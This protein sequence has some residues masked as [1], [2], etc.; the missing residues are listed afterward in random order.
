MYFRPLPILTVLT[1]LILAGL[2]WLGFWQLD[3]MA[4]KQSEI[5]I[6]QAQQDRDPVTLEQA[7]C[8]RANPFSWRVE[9]PEM[10]SG[11]I[12]QI[13]GRDPAGTPGWRIFQAAEVG[14]CATDVYVLA[15]VG[16]LPLN[17]PRMNAIHEGQM[18]L[19]RPLAS[20]AFTPEREPASLE[21]YSFDR[22]AME[23]VLG[24]ADGSLWEQ[25]WLV[26]DFGALPARLDQTPPARHFGYAITWFG[27]SLALLAVYGVFHYTHG[28]LG[29][30]GRK[31]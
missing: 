21:F 14:E 9:R 10:A 23:N 6:W 25:G 18:M 1:A 15:E 30:T 28:R 19:E 3:R 24:L 22:A 11:S 13:Y 4:W 2:I 12:V 5:D 31:D 20:G 8:G 29:F 26:S 17:A 7:Y 16:F 27:M